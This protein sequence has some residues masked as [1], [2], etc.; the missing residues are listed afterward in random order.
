MS[1]ISRIFDKLLNISQE[2]IRYVRPSPQEYLHPVYPWEKHYNFQSVANENKVTLFDHTCDE[3]GDNFKIP[4]VPIVVQMNL[5][6]TEEHH[7]T[8]K[9]WVADVGGYCPSCRRHLCPKH[10]KVDCVNDLKKGKRVFTVICA[11]CE[12]ALEEGPNVNR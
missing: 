12:M 3:C 2:E 1:K 9:Y 6:E 10:A 11:R 4:A 7:I 8:E 5:E